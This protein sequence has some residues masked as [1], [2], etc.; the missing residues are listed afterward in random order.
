M[1]D[2]TAYIGGQPS[3]LSSNSQ[4]ISLAYNHPKNHLGVPIAVASKR[5]THTAIEDALVAGTTRAVSGAV[6]LGLV[7]GA[8]DEQTALSLTTTG[9]RVVDTITSDRSPEAALDGLSRL[10]GSTARFVDEASRYW[11]PVATEVYQQYEPAAALIS[12]LDVTGPTSLAKLTAHAAKHQP[13]VADLLLGE[14]LVEPP[15]PTDPLGNTALAIPSI[16]YSPA[17]CQL[18][19]QLW[20]VGLLTERGASSTALAPL[21]DRWTIEPRHLSV[22]TMEADR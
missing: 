8:S 20:H 22:P 18:K 7:T 12:L 4:V 5:E 21:D 10:H 17:T 6:E 19:T 13:T 3:Q 14:S 16:Y 11:E 2:P 15:A 1:S 9:E